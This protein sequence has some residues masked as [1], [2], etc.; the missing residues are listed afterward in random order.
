MKAA[1]DWSPFEGQAEFEFAEFLY[2]KERMS[3][4][5][6]NA[7]LKLMA[8]KH[9]TGPIFDN[10]DHLCGTIDATELGDAPWMR[11]TLQYCGEIPAT[12]VPEWMTAS[13]DVHYRDL[14]ILVKNI[15]SDTMFKDGIDYVL[16]QE[17]GHGGKCHYENFMSGDWA[18][19]QAV[20]IPLF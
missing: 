3:K 5:N 8:K 2:C 7:L 18:Y 15:F 10:Y 13:Y 12:D 19:I 17:F 4:S 20:H 11:G 9:D 16:Y 6:I 14:R 1:D